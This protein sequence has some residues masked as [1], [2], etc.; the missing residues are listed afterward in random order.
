MKFATAEEMLDYINDNN[1]LYSSL[2]E[3]YV[4]NYN[5]GGSIASYHIDEEEAK[6]LSRLVKTSEEGY[7]GSFLGVG[8]EIY[9]YPSH[10]CYREELLTNLEYCQELIKTDDW[11]RVEDYMNEILDYGDDCPLGGDSTND[12]EDCIYSI[13]YHYDNGECVMR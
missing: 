8:G 12:C 10:E 7:W 6:R 9:D 11:I 1:D 4:F 5:E 2:E 3:I 13:D